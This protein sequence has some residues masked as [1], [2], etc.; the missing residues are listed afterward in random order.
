FDGKKPV[1]LMMGGSTG[2]ASVNAALRAALPDLLQR[3]DILHVCGK[4]NMDAGLT[5]KPGYRQFE[6]LDE[7]LPDAF[8]AANIMLSR[9]G[10][11]SLCEILALRI[12]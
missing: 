3:F 6:Y 5:G 7:Q 12:P 11:N 9:A 4:G 10:A 1:L 2:A 8:A